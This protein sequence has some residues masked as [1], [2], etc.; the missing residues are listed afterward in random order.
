[1]QLKPIPL[2]FSQPHLVRLLK[3]PHPMLFWVQFPLL[4][5]LKLIFINLHIIFFPKLTFALVIFT[6]IFISQLVFPVFF[7][8]NIF[9][10]IHFILR[11]IAYFVY[12][13]LYFLV[14]SSSCSFHHRI[15]YR[16]LSL[17]ELLVI[18]TDDGFFKLRIVLWFSLNYGCFNFI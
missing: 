6:I 3:Q 5:T 2:H 18:F 9:F 12:F 14:S 16:A 10:F 15:Q 11:F 8:I 4:F 1:M 7:F 17:F 13:I